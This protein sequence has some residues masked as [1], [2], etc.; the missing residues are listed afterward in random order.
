MMKSLQSAIN[1]V[2]TKTHL[3]Y[4]INLSGYISYSPPF[5]PIKIIFG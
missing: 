5:F 4:E 2:R 3:H 1:F